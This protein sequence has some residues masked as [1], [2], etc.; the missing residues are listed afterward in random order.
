MVL[1]LLRDGTDVEVPQ[2]F[3]V[4]HR[5]EG[6]CC[7]DDLGTLVAYFSPEEVLAYKVHAFVAEQ[8]QARYRPRRRDRT[9]PS[10]T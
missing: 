10:L 8:A 4:I 1:V 9:R 5:P 3:D 2:A 6:I 7:I